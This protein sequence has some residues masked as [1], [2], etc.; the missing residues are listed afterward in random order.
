MEKKGPTLND[1]EKHR[2]IL[3]ICSIPSF[4]IYMPFIH[5]ILKKDTIEIF[6]KM[7]MLWMVGES[8]ED[9]FETVKKMIDMIGFTSF[10]EGN[11][12]YEF[13]MKGWVQYSQG[14]TTYRSLLTTA[15]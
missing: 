7:T 10:E 12:I 4:D 3:E 13:L 1:E 14:Y 2:I 5:A 11:K 6:R 8:F 9:I 15:T